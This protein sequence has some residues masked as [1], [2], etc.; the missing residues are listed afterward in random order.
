[1]TVNSSQT[2]KLRAQ[3]SAAS[4]VKLATDTWVLLGDLEAS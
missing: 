1:V 3:W 2:L 4:V